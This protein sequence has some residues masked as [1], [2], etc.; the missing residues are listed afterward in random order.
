[1]TEKLLDKRFLNAGAISGTSKE[2]VTKEIVSGRS[3]F[4]KEVKREAFVSETDNPHTIFHKAVSDKVNLNVETWADV[5]RNTYM[6]WG[7]YWVKV[8]LL[9]AFEKIGFSVNVHPDRADV[10]IYLWGSPFQP[11]STFPFFYNSDSYNVMWFYSN[12]DKMT[13]EEM[14]RYHLIFCLSQN[15]LDEIKG[16]HPNIHNEALLSCTD[17]EMPKEQ[18]EKDI[19]LLFVGNARGGLQYGRKAIYWLDLASEMK[20]KI[21]GHKWYLSKYHTAIEKLDDWYSGKYWP[22][23]E[24]NMLYNRAKITLVDCHEDMAING[25]V[26]MKI[27]DI[28]Q[29]GGFVISNFNSGIFE[30]F[31]DTVPQYK[32]KKEMNYLIKYFYQNERVRERFRVKALRKIQGENFTKRA[33]KIAEVLINLK[34][35]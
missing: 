24:L 11:R 20:V 1:M 9:K 29:S 8:R 3:R 25:F 35:I 22:Y 13:K 18:H 6:C 30:I 27:F 10:T 16:W 5:D 21:Y 15:Y 12:P 34:V 28:L 26:P 31:E 32:T 4:Q 23:E 17:F 19:D 14:N 33:E 2:L 7:D